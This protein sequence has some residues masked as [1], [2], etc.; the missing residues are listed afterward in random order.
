MNDP[1]V[2]I[3]YRCIYC[4][5]SIVS[6]HHFGEMVICLFGFSGAELN[7]IPSVSERGV[8]ACAH[9]ALCRCGCKLFDH[10]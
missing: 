5:G 6:C 4:L 8:F 1:W 3:L 10:T 7:L 9:V 2:C